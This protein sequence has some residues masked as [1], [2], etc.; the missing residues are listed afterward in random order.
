MCGHLVGAWMCGWG[1]NLDHG[2]QPF[3]VV[4]TAITMLNHVHGLEVE[5]TALFGPLINIFGMG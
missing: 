2:Q 4:V 1:C 3:K 5:K